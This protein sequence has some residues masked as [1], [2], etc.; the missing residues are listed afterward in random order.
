[1]SLGTRRIRGKNQLARKHSL[2]VNKLWCRWWPREQFGPLRRQL[3]EFKS[4]L[5]TRWLMIPVTEGPELILIL[6]L[7]IS[8]WTPISWAAFQL[9]R[10][11]W[12]VHRSF[13][14]WFPVDTGRRR[15]PCRCPKFMLT[16]VL[17]VVDS[18]GR[19]LK[20]L[21]TLQCCTFH[22]LVA[23]ALLQLK[24]KRK[25]KGMVIIRVRFANKFTHCHG[26]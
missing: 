22:L 6:L 1:M 24:E 4:N 9:S 23:R 20:S 16:T 15:W 26:P 7:L 2:R 14:Y 21:V 11:I 3:S 8:G 12:Q 13:Y 5:V 10:Q 18:L 19:T 25:R 17:T